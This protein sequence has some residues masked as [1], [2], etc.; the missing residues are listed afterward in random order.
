MQPIYILLFGAIGIIIAIGVGLELSKTIEDFIVYFLFWLLY[1]ITIATF[2]NIIIVVNYY[3]VMKDK[4]GTPGTQGPVGDAGDSGDAG[5]C[6]PACRDSICENQI[7]DMIS[8]ELQKKTTG[9][10]K[11]R[12]NN[13]YIKSKIKQMCASD[14]FKQLVPYNG[15]Y[16]LV[17]YLKDIWKI[18]FNN[19]YEAG[20]SKYFETISAENEFD[21]LSENPFFEIKKYDVFYWGMGKQYRPKVVNK[22]YDSIDGNNPDLTSSGSILRVSKTTLYDKLGD[23]SGARAVNRVSFWRPRQ[24][25][26][27]GAVYY[28]VG[29]LAIG[30]STK[31]DNIR[32]TK[33]VGRISF[34]LPLKGPNR[35]TIL[36]SGDVKGPIDYNLVWKNNS[37]KQFWIW[38]PIAPKNYISLGDVITYNANPPLTG[39]KAPIRC[40]F[41][42]LTIRATPNGNVLWSSYGSPNAINTMLLGF[43]PNTALGSFEG[44]NKANCYNL[45]RAVVG[46][47]VNN[48]P[49]S[50][51]NGSFY[52]LD[53]SKYDTEYIIGADV[54]NPP[55]NK[56]A[57]K[58]GKGYINFPKKDAKYS[59]LPYL[60]LK[61]NAVLKHQMTNIKLNAKLIPNAISNAYLISKDDKCLNYAEKTVKLDACDE[62]IS[63]QTFSI[64]FTGNKKNECKLQHYE[65]KKIINFKND[66]Y[67]LVNENEQT[68][69]EYQMFIME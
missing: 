22:C 9:S 18:W 32:T 53:E 26:Y 41:Q 43:K 61:N 31:N 21:W 51:I 7:L 5:L 11:L 40:V 39:E 42:D 15:P 1:I 30:P 35:E 38:R 33:Y 25:T 52:Y 29:D 36:V 17:N 37:G 12:F 16:N 64:I 3:L 23:D 54:G 56:D 6:D 63:S 24:F 2:I 50:D 46:L 48:I 55:S 34:P 14:E 8:T 62:E 44:A 4:T 28:P 58:V 68:D 67:T 19:L 57:N 66:L 69:I 45:F 13:I 60:N 59:I 49:A 27:K 10:S 65:S 20:G 47:N